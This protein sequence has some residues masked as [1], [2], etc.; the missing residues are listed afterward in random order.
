MKLGITQRLFLSMLAASSL[1][2]VCMF[3]V[4]QWSINRGFLQ[5]LAAQD[6]VV[7]DEV[8]AKLEEL[9]EE[10]GSLDFLKGS[11]RRWAY[12]LIRSQPGE[13]PPPGFPEAFR[14]PPAPPEGGARSRF[15]PPG[16]NRPEA[17]LVVLDGR[18]VP[19]IEHQPG[20]GEAQLKPLVKDGRT[21][22]FVGLLP[23]RHFLDPFQL[24]FLH[25]Q[26]SGLVF[27]AA[28]VVLLAALFSLPLARRLVRPLR[29]LAAATRELSSGKYAT[30]VPVASS[31]ELGRLAHDFNAL[32]LTLEKNEELR[33]R[34]VADV[35]HELRTPL[36]VLRG[37]I[38]ALLDGVR[39]TT[40]ETIRSL[41]AEALRLSRL[42]EDL[43]QLSLSDVGGLTYR[44]QDLDLTELLEDSLDAFRSELTR[45]GLAL[46]SHLPPAGECSLF[47]DPE[48]LAQ[49]FRNVLDNALKYSDSGGSVA[50][51][52]S[53]DGGR[54]TV[55]F[56]DSAPG[57]PEAALEKLFDR[58]YRVEG[59]RN[60]GSGGA[61]LGLAICRSIVEGHDGTISASP[62]PLGGVWIRIVLPMA[63]RA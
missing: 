9:H 38:E 29:A 46:V 45:K 49:L 11:P 6:R 57:V 40:P 2:V 31:D 59:S 13:K 44:K 14:S 39:A 18:R 61:G 24:R 3:L 55:D 41:H 30:R 26:K 23:P 10:E 62:S 19:L 22:G 43:Y 51:R 63:E 15:G 52:V 56:E 36:A 4:A 53:C 33:R 50:V 8:A 48:R 5:Y 17:R 54:A 7:L 47:G 58:L 12:F 34:W 35:S 28:G 32:A 27:A 16:A 1:T 20:S 60:R 25:E 42:V 21:F 37:E